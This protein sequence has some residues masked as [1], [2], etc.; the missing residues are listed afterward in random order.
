[1]LNFISCNAWHLSYFDLNPWTYSLLPV[2]F[3]VAHKVSPLITIFI[4]N[5]HSFIITSYIVNGKFCPVLKIE[6]ETG[7]T[8]RKYW[9][10]YLS[11]KDNLLLSFYSTFWLEI[12]IFNKCPILLDNYFNI[13]ELIIWCGNQC[14]FMFS[15][16]V[17]LNLWVLPMIISP[18]SFEY[19]HSFWICC[20]CLDGCNKSCI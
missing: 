9:L 1:M 4:F 18:C 10:I 20:L 12:V 8:N 17:H 3:V 7:K 16:D 13:A 19:L 14:N 5:A 6:K 15:Q 11:W 2:I